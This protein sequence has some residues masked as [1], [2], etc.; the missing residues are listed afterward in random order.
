MPCIDT[1]KQGNQHLVISRELPET[2]DI[3]LLIK[4]I[5]EYGYRFA[6]GHSTKRSAHAIHQDGHEMERQDRYAQAQRFTMLLG[7]FLHASGIM[8]FRQPRS[9]L[10]SCLRTS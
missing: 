2:N 6:V 4:V 8:A 5:G 7:R 10:P 9:P 3:Y 1:G